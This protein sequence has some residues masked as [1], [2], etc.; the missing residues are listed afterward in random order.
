MNARMI[1]AGIFLLAGT[2]CVSQPPTIAHANIG[3]AVTGVAAAIDAAI[4][5]RE[6]VGLQRAL[7]MAAN[8]VSLAAA[9]PDA[10]VNLQQ[11]APV[12]TRNV[13]RVVE[14]CELIALLGKDLAASTSVAEAGVLQAAINKLAAANLDGDDADG[15]GKSGGTPAEYGVIQL[16]AELDAL[17]ARENPPYRT[18]DQRNPSKVVPAQG[19]L[20]EPQLIEAVNRAAAAARAERNLLRCTQLSDIAACDE[21]VA[22]RPDDPQIL[23]AR[24]DALLKANRP[25]EAAAAFRRAVEIKLASDALPARIAA[26]EQLR[27]KLATDCTTGSGAVAVQAC[28]AAL[29]R[30]GADE[31]TIQRRKGRLLQNMGESSRALDAYIAA[32]T[33]KPADRAVAVAIVA[34]TERGKRRDAIA[35]EA[36]GSA[37]LT[38]KRFSEAA[39][40][41]RQAKALSPELPDVN[42]K[43]AAA[44]RL[45]RTQPRRA[46]P[47]AAETAAAE[48]PARVY[49][50]EAPTS[51]SR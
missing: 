49:S 23:V 32:D 20:S 51:Q 24:G 26:A 9:S 39:A 48:P 43:L 28:D 36:R 12:F 47:P 45:A 15:D 5:S 6:Q 42:K 37:F 41:L 29:V 17:V 27:A 16:R 46:E 34:L 31:F 30:G 25:V 22:G 13:I 10:S 7:L 44:E 1:V 3:Y 19:N 14:R 33:V 18:A 50:N 4:N 40:V 38:L 8:H 2:G 21:T 11:S 35:L